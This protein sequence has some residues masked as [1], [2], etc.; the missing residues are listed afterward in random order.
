LRYVK[1]LFF[2]MY[3]K[4]EKLEIETFLFK[5]SQSNQINKIFKNYST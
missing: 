4:E 5:I 2:K 3:L 1:I